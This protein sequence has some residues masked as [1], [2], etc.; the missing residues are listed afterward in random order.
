MAFLKKKNGIILV[1]FIT[2]IVALILIFLR[3]GIKRN[4]Y[5]TKNTIISKTNAE[6]LL[7]VPFIPQ[8]GFAEKEIEDVGCEEVSILMVKGFLD[9][10]MLN[11]E[12]ALTEIKKMIN[13]QVV[14]YGNHPLLDALK[15]GSLVEKTYD[16]KPTILADANKET[17]IEQ[18]KNNNPVIV[19]VLAKKLKNPFYPNYQGYHTLVVV[20]INNNN[21]IVND[22]GTTSGSNYIYPFDILEKAMYN[23]EKEE[24]DILILKKV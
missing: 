10:E 24:K 20:G 2:S 12:E 11:E 22:P 9:N 17:I 6:I 1:L 4:F 13:S 7:N 14:Q 5:Q 16:L 19:P 15:I 18:L 23:F 8:T 3:S 21:F